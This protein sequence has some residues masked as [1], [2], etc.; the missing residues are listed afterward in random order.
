MTGNDALHNAHVQCRLKVAL[1]LL[2]AYADV[3]II[4]SK[5]DTSL[6]F[7]IYPCVCLKRVHVASARG[8]AGSP[9][10]MNGNAVLCACVVKR[11]Q[12][13]AAF[14]CRLDSWIRNR[15]FALFS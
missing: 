8:V 1:L 9:L 5:R 2:Y 7:T 11:A 15:N 14:R 3:Q 10:P 4:K 13:F 6:P 12:G